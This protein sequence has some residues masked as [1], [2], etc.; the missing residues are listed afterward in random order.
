MTMTTSNPVSG[1]AP[2][3]LQSDCGPDHHRPSH[4][5]HRKARTALGAALV[6]ASLALA[7]CALPV[8]GSGNGSSNGSHASGATGQQPADFVALTTLAP[9]RLV[10]E[11]RD[12]FVRTAVP[13]GLDHDPARFDEIRLGRHTA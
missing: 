2:C 12:M 10:T 6:A 4:R 3:A 5:H 13:P 1:P 9:G 7:G 8:G 11:A